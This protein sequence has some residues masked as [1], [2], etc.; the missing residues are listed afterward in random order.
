[1]RLSSGKCKS[2]LACCHDGWT[3]PG[4]EGGSSRV[5]PTMVLSREK[6]EASFVDEKE[7]AT[8]VHQPPSECRFSLCRSPLRIQNGSE[9]P[10]L[11]RSFEVFSYVILYNIA[12]SWHLKSLDAAN[13]DTR[14]LG[15]RKSLKLYEH[16]NRIM[17]SGNLLQGNPLPY[18]ALICN[19]GSLYMS[20]NDHGMAMMCQDHLLSSIMCWI[21][22][23]RRDDH[24]WD[25]LLDSFLASAMQQFFVPRTAPAA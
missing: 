21:D 6:A 1:M 19:L 15:L 10:L 14:S 4:G 5:F 12:L 7:R 20:V 23:N 24:E 11:P 8:G 25:L 9:L 13:P 17:T 16:A 3:P 22:Y 18:M 2:S